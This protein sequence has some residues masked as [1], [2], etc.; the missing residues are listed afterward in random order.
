MMTTIRSPT[1]VQSLVKEDDQN[2][3]L[4]VN[5]ESA[6]YGANS[7]NLSVQ[8]TSNTFAPY[9]FPVKDIPDSVLNDIRLCNGNILTIRPMIPT[10]ANYCVK[11]AYRIRD[12]LMDK[13]DKLLSP[14]DYNF[15]GN[16]LKNLKTMFNMKFIIKL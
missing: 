10:D 6:I 9:I 12:F 1:P 7:Y 13:R 4:I 15:W 16:D 11:A 8:N 2:I 14:S 3:L 5:Y